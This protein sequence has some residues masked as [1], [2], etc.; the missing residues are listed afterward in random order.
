[1]QVEEVGNMVY[2]HGEG[3][4]VQGCGLLSNVLKTAYQHFILGGFW[5]RF[6]GRRDEMQRHY[7]AF[8]RAQLQLRIIPFTGAKEFM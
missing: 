8:S 4:G 5:R 3:A 7:M 2:S 1:M 6:I